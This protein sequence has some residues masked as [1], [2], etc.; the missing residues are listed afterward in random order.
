MLIAVATDDGTH[1]AQHFGRCGFFSIWQYRDGE[2]PF[3]HGVRVNTFTM[4]AMNNP[5]SIGG[6]QIAPSPGEVPGEPAIVPNLYDLETLRAEAKVG[7][8]GEKQHSH[9]KVLT[10]LADV[11]VVISA[12]MGRRAVVDLQ[13]N[14]KEIFI[15]QEPVI[16]TAVSQYVEG[17]LESG[18]ACHDH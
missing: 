10:G 18:E 14:D 3:N 5:G 2:K 17:T 4:H 13:A 9:D 1:I 16:E 11:K 7:S 12:G 8:H 15:T 6:V